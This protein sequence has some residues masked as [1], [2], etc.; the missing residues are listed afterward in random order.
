[1]QVRGMLSW[2][3]NFCQSELH[4]LRWSSAL[5]TL[6]QSLFLLYNLAH[7]GVPYLELHILGHQVAEQ[8]PTFN[9]DKV[10]V[11]VTLRWLADL[12]WQGSF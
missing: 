6:L 7:F 8:L 4:L 1:M 12:P 10:G 2:A 9:T 11:H 3:Q 5:G